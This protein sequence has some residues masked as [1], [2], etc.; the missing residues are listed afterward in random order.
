MYIQV[1]FYVDPP[2]P[3]YQNLFPYFEDVSDWK[4]LGLHLLPET[5]TS[6]INDIDKNHKHDVAECR[7]ALIT[8]YL[9]VG[10]L[11]WQK[12]IY[13]LQKSGYPNIVEKI[14]R[15]IFNID[16]PSTRLP[17]DHKRHKQLPST[18]GKLCLLFI[19]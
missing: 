18:I 2:P 9:K 15:D 13:A 14:K 6:R 4:K 1:S 16:D 19:T 11:S 3:N 8:E 12:V 7:W 10:E 17:T 5:C